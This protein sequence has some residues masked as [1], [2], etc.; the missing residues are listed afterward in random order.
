MNIPYSSSAVDIPNASRWL[1][2]RRYQ[3]TL[4]FSSSAMLAT[5]YG[6]KGHTSVD[7]SHL[8]QRRRNQYT[9]PSSSPM[10]RTEYGKRKGINQLT[11]ASGTRGDGTNTRG[12]FRLPCYLQGIAKA[13]LISTWFTFHKNVIR[14]YLIN[15]Y[16]LSLLGV[17]TFDHPTKSMEGEYAF[18]VCTI[19]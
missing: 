14:R 15:W 13:T 6:K 7:S 9:S 4:S 11:A 8:H 18:L 16:N 12:H 1:Q 3:Y 19:Y 17:T 10:L 5:G 2:R